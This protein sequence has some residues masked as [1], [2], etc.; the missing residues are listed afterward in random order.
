MRRGSAIVTAFVFLATGV[1]AAPRIAPFP[2]TGTGIHL[3]MVFNY[4]MNGDY[5]AE[6]GKVDAVWG[7]DVPA[8][9][10]GVYNSWYIP[11]NVDDFTNSVDWYLQNHPDWLAYKCDKVTLAYVPGSAQ[12]PLDFANPEVRAYQWA[13]WIDAKLDQ[14]YPSIAVDLLAL[15]NDQNRCGHYA[16]DGTTWVPEYDSGAVDL[17]KYRRDVLKWERLT[18]RHVHDYSPTATMQVNVTYPYHTSWP[19][20]NIALMTT[21]DLVLDERGF[22]EFGFPPALPSPEDWQIIVDKIDTVHKKGRCYTL[23]NEV[24]GTNDDI[25]EAQRQ[26]VI[27][28]YLLTKTDRDSAKRNC[29]YMYITGQQDYGALVLSDDYTIAIGRPMAERAARN[30]AW[31]RRYSGGLALVNPTLSSVTFKLPPGDWTD[32]SGNPVRRRMTMAK[33][34]GLLLLKAK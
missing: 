11:F 6:A 17:K 16:K 24:P 32:L 19:N 22:T 14:G 13:S 5:E 30:G 29:D 12:A 25:T 21:S 33:Q 15:T 18:Y 7:S 1:Q 28:N 34:T 9:P 27:A 20:Q 8:T 3:E 26:W 4:K 31:E 23:V 10:S 2:E